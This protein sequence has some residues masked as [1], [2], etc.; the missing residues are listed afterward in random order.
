MPIVSG[1]QAL[2]GLAPVA[3]PTAFGTVVPTS[4]FG[5]VAASATQVA[6]ENADALAVLI[7]GGAVTTLP[8]V[9]HTG[10]EVDGIFSGSAILDPVCD[11]RAKETNR[12]GFGGAFDQLWGYAKRIIERRSNETVSSKASNGD[13]FDLIKAYGV[14]FRLFGEIKP[15]ESVLKILARSVKRTHRKIPIIVSNCLQCS[16]VL[17]K[18]IIANGGAP[19][20]AILGSANLGVDPVGIERPQGWSGHAFL[21]GNHWVTYTI[22]DGTHMAIDVTT[23]S[24]TNKGADIITAPSIEELFKKLSFCYGGEWK[25]DLVSE[26]LLDKG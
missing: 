7:V 3:A 11:Y 20:T 5:G 10:A 25:I 22:A 13:E 6:A 24:C 4:A 12:S 23:G 1:F 26:A 15:S 2:P 17:A 18:T 8:T 9:V 14:R 21:F 16:S 19:E